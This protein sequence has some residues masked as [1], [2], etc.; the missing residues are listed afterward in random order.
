MELDNGPKDLHL[1]T[2]CVYVFVCS[3]IPDQW[4]SNTAFQS[5]THN[6]CTCCSGTDMQTKREHAHSPIIEHAH[7]F[8]PSAKMLTGKHTDVHKHKKTLEVERHVCELMSPWR[9]STSH[10]AVELQQHTVFN[11]AANKHKLERAAFQWAVQRLVKEEKRERVG[12]VR[13]H[14]QIKRKKGERW[15]Q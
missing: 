8:S 2:F 14:Q 9:F 4:G 15:N 3:T 7:T 12:G 1:H 10:T 6:P 13:G 11:I 5:F